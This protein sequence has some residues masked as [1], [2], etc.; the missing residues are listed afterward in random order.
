M[1]IAMYNAIQIN[2]FDSILFKWFEP[3]LKLKV[4]YELNDSCYIQKS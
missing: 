2:C 4:Y 3:N 1:H